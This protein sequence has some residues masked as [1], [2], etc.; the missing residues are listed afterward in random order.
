[1]CK[2]VRVYLSIK[3]GIWCGV[4]VSKILHMAA[5]AVGLA[6]WEAQLLGKGLRGI[7]VSVPLLPP[8]THTRAYKQ[9]IPTHTHN[10]YHSCRSS[11]LV[12]R[13][14]WLVTPSFYFPCLTVFYILIYLFSPTKRILA[15]ERQRGSVWNGVGEAEWPWAQ[16]AAVLWLLCQ[17]MV[18]GRMDAPC[19]SLFL[20][21]SVHLCLFLFLWH[22]SINSSHVR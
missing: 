1:M 3:L 18:D 16:V 2:P 9:Y 22:F 11:I 12:P 13:S 15:W 4:G 6:K 20:S 10:L 21:R 8:N 19:L 7:S 14:C 5:G 17:V